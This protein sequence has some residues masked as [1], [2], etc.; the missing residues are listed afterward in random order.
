MDEQQTAMENYVDKS[1]GSGIIELT[2]NKNYT[3]RKVNE[4]GQQIIDKPTYNKITKYFV[5]HDGIII[6]GEV[7]ES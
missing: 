7:A 4:D 1:A 6:R 2:R 3:H 5:K